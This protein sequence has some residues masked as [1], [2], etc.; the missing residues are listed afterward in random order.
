LPLLA[1]LGLYAAAL[2]AWLALRRQS[3]SLK[4]FT[5]EAESRVE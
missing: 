5:T 4:G 1:G 3:L 2:A